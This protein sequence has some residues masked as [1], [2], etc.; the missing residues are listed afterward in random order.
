MERMNYRT[1]FLS[2]LLLA[3]ASFGAENGL[4][5]LVMPDAKVVVGVDVTRAKA[6]SLGQLFMQN[7]NLHD[8]ELGKLTSLT[9]FD[10]RRDLSE[11]VMASVDTNT[12]GKNALM[13]VRG[14]FD[15][16]RIKTF[17]AQN[18]LTAVQSVQGVELF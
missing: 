18:G 8:D 12:S 15:A 5:N 1:V 17:V 9:G 2:G 13:L 6:S 7:I 16:A 11:V 4:L 14:N 3:T 10:P